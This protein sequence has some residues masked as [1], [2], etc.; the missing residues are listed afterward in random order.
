MKSIPVP[1]LPTNR[2][3]VVTGR[4]FNTRSMQVNK[5]GLDSIAANTHATAAFLDA[6][7]R[8]CAALPPLGYDEPPPVLLL[9]C[10][11]LCCGA[12]Q[13]WGCLAPR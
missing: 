2:R 1:L 6:L 3:S 5:H 12:Q 10:D 4:L 11:A 8:F 7:P 13:D 9:L